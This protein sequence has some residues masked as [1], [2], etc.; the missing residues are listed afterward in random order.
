MSAGLISSRKT[1][2][3][4]VNLSTSAGY[5]GNLASAA[6]DTLVSSYT[7]TVY[8]VDDATGSDSNDG[9]TVSTALK[10]IDHFNFLTSGIT[11]GVMAVIYPGTYTVTPVTGGVAA[12][13]TSYGISDYTYER[14]YVGYAGQTY[15]SWTVTA[16]W[17]DG[18]L[19]SFSNA[20]SAMYGIVLQRDNGGRT[21]TYSCAFFKNPAFLGKLYNCVIQEMNANYN[22][23]IGYANSG[24]PGSPSINYC[25]FAVYE[26]GGNDY[27]GSSNLV[28][29]NCFFN[30]TPSTPSTLN[31]CQTTTDL[32]TYS[33]TTYTSDATA[34]SSG[35]YFGTYAWPTP[36]TLNPYATNTGV[37]TYNSIYTIVTFTTSGTFTVLSPLTADYLIIAGGGGGG[38]RYGGGGGAGGVIS[39]TASLSAGIYNITVG[40]GGAGGT[41][42]SP[43]TAGS[44]GSNSVFNSLT[45][46]GGGGGGS[47]GATGSA[48]MIGRNGG[49][50]GGGTGNSSGGSN[51]AGGSGTS[52][53]GNSG[54]LGIS[55]VSPYTTLSAGGG[56]GYGSAGQNGSIT[57]TGSGGDGG[58]GLTNSLTGSAVQYAGGGGGGTFGNSGSR[59]GGSGTYG[60]GTGSNNSTTAGGNGTAN[61]GGGGGGGGLTTAGTDGSAGG[62][63]GAGVVIIRYLT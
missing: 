54:G 60:G 1:S 59:L 43:G 52:G 17:R 30:Y 4:N 55:S 20:N 27:S 45:A 19:C 29:N 40:A 34:I 48:I 49:S 25:T 32:Q 28:F 36:V 9:L 46:I 50:G 41:A 16:T 61:T 23:T 56:G 53:Q 63:G 51:S 31:S 11:T 22:W 5:A 47:G 7:G 57:S 18:P 15:I 39:G 38:G 14:I 44:D 26:A 6:Y 58:S 8:Y 33:Y 13:G 12:T 2:V 37:T 3:S 24:W 42:P 10:T 62:T 35:V 21:N